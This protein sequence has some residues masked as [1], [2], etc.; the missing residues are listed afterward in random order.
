[1]SAAFKSLLS[2]ARHTLTGTSTTTH[3]APIEGLFPKVDP[4]IDG[5]DCDHDCE[6]CAVSY[7]RWFKTDE[8]DK[9]YGHVKEW[10][11]HVL[12]A[13]GKT[14]WVRDVT[15]E[16]GSVM[17]AIEKATVKP[18]Q[19]V[20]NQAETSAEISQ[21]RSRAPRK[22]T[23]RLETHA[24]SLEYSYAIPLRQLLRANN[25]PPPARLYP[26]RERYPQVREHPHSGFR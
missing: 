18:S 16:K 1:M 25:G 12:V 6:S 19:G 22:L 4:A 8:E 14:D 7:P 11:Q 23:C 10:S 13:T 24:I 20:S 2:T 5:E 9:L 26:R 15:D 21:I 3:G 17:E